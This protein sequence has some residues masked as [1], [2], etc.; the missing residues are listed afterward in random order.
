MILRH[1]TSKR[2]K[3]LEIDLKLAPMVI[4]EFGTEDRSVLPAF[5]P[6]VISESTGL[7]YHADDFRRKWRLIADMAGVPKTVRNQDSR[8]G[9]ITEATQAGAEL[10][11]VKHAA[12]HADISQ[13]QRYSRAGTEK[14]ATVQVKRV[15]HRFRTSG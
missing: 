10:E 12:T 14:V 3:M 9:G 2:G 8:A 6:L 1:V 7:P 11:H 13:T 5:G 15:S 4:E